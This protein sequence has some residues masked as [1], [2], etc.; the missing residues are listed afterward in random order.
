MGNILHIPRCNKCKTCKSVSICSDCLIYICNKCVKKC[1]TCRS[2]NLC[3]KH[4]TNSCSI[5]DKC[6]Y[7]ITI[8]ELPF[9]IS[10][11]SIPE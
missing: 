11:E 1:S 4:F 3:P 7:R 5:C 10:L 8:E 6:K 2:N 9:L